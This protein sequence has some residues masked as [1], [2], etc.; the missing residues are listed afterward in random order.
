[1][2]AA[3]AAGDERRACFAAGAAAPQRQFSVQ[4]RLRELD[5]PTGSPNSRAYA[6]PRT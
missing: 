5:P 4:R 2:R 3:A 6:M 1:M